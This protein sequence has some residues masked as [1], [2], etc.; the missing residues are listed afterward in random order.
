MMDPRS[1]EGQPIPDEL[2]ILPSKDAQVFPHM[3][4]PLAI[5][6]DQW[7]KMIEEAHGGQ[8]VIGLFALKDADGEPVVDNLAEVGT[9]VAVIRML[10]MPDGNAQALLQGLSRVKTEEI[11]EQ[12]P[13][14]KARV[15]VLT[16]S[17]D[18]SNE[19]EAMHRN[20][21]GIFQN[22]VS[23]SPTLPNEL[24][25]TATN[26]SEASRLADFVA[27]A[28]NLTQAE[29]Q[30]VL[31]TLDVNARIRR[32]TS[33]A[34]R[35][36]EVLEI[37][38]R[39]QSEMKSQMEK[40]QKEYYLREQMKAIQKELGEADEK[41][42][43]VGE[44][45]QRVEEAGL[46]PEALKEAQRELDRLQ[47]MPQASPEHAL[48]RTYLDWMVSLPWKTTTADNM[49]IAQAAKVLDEDHYGL[50]RIKDRILEYLAVRKLRQE[51]R[52]PILCF[53]GPPG[54]GK[55]S[56]GQSIAR[57]LGRKFIRISLGG[58][59]DEADVR[60]HRRTYVGALPGRIIQGLRRAGSNNPVFM[61]DEVDKLSAGLQGDP[62]AA[63]LE[64]LDPAQNST[65]V[66]HYLDVA[67]DLSKVM[68]VTTANVLDTIPPPLRDRMEIIQLPGYTENEKLEIAKRYL[69]P[70]QTTEHGITLEQ[71]EFTDD[72]L[73]EV[74]N[75]YTREAGVRNLEREI[76]TITRKIA[77]KVAEGEQQKMLVRQQDIA[78][79][80]GA[81]RF[82]HE[83]RDEDDEIGVATGLAW[84]PTGGEVL[85]VETSCVPGRGQLVLTGQLGE[86]MQESVRAALTYIRSRAD[87]L[88]LPTNFHEKWDI[89]VHVPAGA[90]PK[91][92]P[93]AGITMATSLVSSLTKRPVHKEVGMTGEITL[94]GK[95]LPIGG[96]K[97]KV[98]AAHRAG[99]ETVLFPQENEKDLDEIPAQVRQEVKL[100]PVSNVDQ[101]ISVALWAEKRQGDEQSS[102]PAMQP[103]P[104]Q[105]ID[106]Q[107]MDQ[108]PSPA[109]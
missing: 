64:V 29:K 51:M 104:P 91:D 38:S 74:I 9:A 16:E 76:A 30:E 100:I 21:Q 3:L 102:A 44:L 80:L 60:G 105:M 96:L 84:T 36:L 78:T 25:I 1:A 99:L 5:V 47:R 63:L 26:L 17:E 56:L 85:F 23:L 93:S 77:R 59:R 97:E 68:F 69:V 86:V 83:I 33:F 45:R 8:R 28:L 65:F 75:R 32:V 101:V 41:E 54:V 6:G 71:I 31:S 103:L 53:V 15:T 81:W 22:V 55:T 42:G 90:V 92:G 61:L 20:L 107:T 12:E 2:Y 40:T 24:A 109:E 19:T 11:L 94:R 95:V 70:R 13:Y 52:G 66:D 88:G 106:Q 46:P 4:V 10:R 98:L 108:P 89:H 57:A 72:A 67:F 62:S 34:N 73:R 82:R 49:D 43:S 50:D 48:I 39:I 7:V 79:F 87:K 14:I 37:G 58:V 27:A 18:K 35:E